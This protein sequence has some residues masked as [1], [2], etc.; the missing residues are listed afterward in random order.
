[1]NCVV[2]TFSDMSILS[3]SLHSVG[4]L[5]SMLSLISL[6]SDLT[7]SALGLI[8]MY[9]HVYKVDFKLI[10]PA[11]IVNKLQNQSQH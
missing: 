4:S 8:N 9:V 11:V 7:S 2:S 3:L 1:M 10:V 5:H 6:A